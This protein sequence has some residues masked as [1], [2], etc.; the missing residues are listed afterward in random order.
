MTSSGAARSR[1]STSCEKPSPN[2]EVLRER[3]MVSHAWLLSPPLDQ[4]LTSS[5]ALENATTGLTLP[6]LRFQD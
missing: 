4:V 3:P 5:R 2:G 6:S 1:W